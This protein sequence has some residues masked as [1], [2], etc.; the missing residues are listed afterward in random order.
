MGFGWKHAA[1]ATIAT[2]VAAGAL[3]AGA[4]P[5]DA[6]PIMRIGRSG[7]LGYW[8]KGEEGLISLGPVGGTKGA[9]AEPFQQRIHVAFGTHVVAGERHHTIRVNGERGTDHAHVRLAVQL[10]LTI[11]GITLVHRQIRV[12]Q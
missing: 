10:L 9:S 5:A 2:I 12:A 8:Y 4:A 3:M 6:A 11:G 1:R 7:L